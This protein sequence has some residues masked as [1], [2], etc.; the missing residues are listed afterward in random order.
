MQLSHRTRREQAARARVHLREVE[1][2]FAALSITVA[3][4]TVEWEEQLKPSTRNL[5]LELQRQ[6][7]DA[8][9]EVIRLEKLA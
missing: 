4:A 9:R 3:R 1:D 2:N 6:V 7:E 8:R 5:W